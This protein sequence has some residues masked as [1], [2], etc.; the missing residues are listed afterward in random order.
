MYSY[1]VTTVTFPNYCTGM[2]FVLEALFSYW[3]VVEHRTVFSKIFCPRLLSLQLGH[4]TPLLLAKTILFKVYHKG[5]YC[6]YIGI[7]IFC[8]DVI[9]II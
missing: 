8:N 5:Y 4:M 3:Y 9:S 6:T 7:T 1:N 2:L